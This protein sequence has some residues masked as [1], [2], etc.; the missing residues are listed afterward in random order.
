MTITIILTA[1][2]GSII[3]GIIRGYVPDNYQYLL[4]VLN[5]NSYTSNITNF[6][7]KDNNYVQN[8]SIKVLNVL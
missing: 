8:S 7:L 5:W 1:A 6:R 3:G 2:I 4:G